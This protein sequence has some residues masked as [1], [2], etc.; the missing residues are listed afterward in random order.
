MLYKKLYNN[1]E[2]VGEFGVLANGKLE[3]YFLSMM[4]VGLRVVF[5]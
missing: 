1:D 2:L 4:M 5:A 3:R